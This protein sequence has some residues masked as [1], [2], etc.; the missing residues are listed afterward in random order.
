MAKKPTYEEL[1]QRVKELENGVFDPKR[2]E[3]EEALRE[4]E[5]RFRM[6][7]EQAGDTVVVHN[8]EGQFVEVNE[9]ACS[10]LGYSRDELMAISAADIEVG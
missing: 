10:S 7:F 3:E 6:F 9:R 1:E 8:L 4:S 2:P 5:E